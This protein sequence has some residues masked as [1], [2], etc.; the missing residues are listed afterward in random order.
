MAAGEE[1]PEMLESMSKN[2]SD[3]SQS[4]SW[5]TCS[6]VVFASFSTSYLYLRG[7]G[8]HQTFPTFSDGLQSLS[9]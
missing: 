4:V 1:G 9:L 8:L 6:I 7:R 3:D 2:P 5:R